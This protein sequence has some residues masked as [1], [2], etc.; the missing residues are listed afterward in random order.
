VRI[1]LAAFACRPNSASED[2]IGWSIL[3]LLSRNHEVGVITHPIR[4]QGIEQGEDRELGGKVKFV[5]A[6]KKFTW[7]PIRLVAQIQNRLVYLQWLKDAQRVANEWLTRE[8]FDLMHHVTITTWRL[9]PVSNACG[10]PLVWGPLGGAAIYPPRLTPWLSP[11]SRVFES[12]RTISSQ[13]STLDPRVRRSARQASQIICVNRE[14]AALMKKL[15]NKSD[16]TVHLLNAAFFSQS[17][18]S[19]YREILLRRT[20][21]EPLRAF[22]GGF[23]VGSKGIHFALRALARVKEAGCVVPFTV[24]S[25]GPERGFLESQA[26]KLGL[27]AQVVFRPPFSG[28]EYRKALADHNLFLLPSFREGSAITILE[29]M[30]CGQVPLV[31]KASTQGETVTPECGFAVPVGSANQMIADLASALLRLAQDPELRLRMAWEAH[32]RVAEGY[33]EKHFET[34][35]ERVYAMALEQK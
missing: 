8:T 2:Q 23:L 10:L 26:R 28:D 16:A 35:L 11:V 21:G 3:K 9:P 18:I 7:H 32:R 30:L 33:S 22:A 12:A 13:I 27:G 5:Y 15:G 4:Q 14:T 24:A 34:V 17:Q 20:A 1:L 31:V 19:G 25:E 6:G 29:A